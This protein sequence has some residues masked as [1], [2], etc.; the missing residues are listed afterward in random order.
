MKLR[1]WEDRCDSNRPD[2]REKAY[3]DMRDIQELLEIAVTGGE[4]VEA[5]AAWLAEDFIDVERAR[6]KGFL[7]LQ[8]A[9]WTELGI[10]LNE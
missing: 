6:L 4:R 5:A 8:Q 2:K 1:G 9:L 7:G 10:G 3:T